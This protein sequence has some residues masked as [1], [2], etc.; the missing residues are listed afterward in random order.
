VS[1]LFV[2]IGMLTTLKPPTVLNLPHLKY[3]DVSGICA[4][5]DVLKAASNL[6]DLRIDFDC[7]KILIDNES[8]CDLLQQRIIRLDV[9]YWTDMESDVFQRLRHL[10]IFQN[11]FK[12]LSESILSTILAQS[13]I[14][15]L[16][17]LIFGSKVPDEI[18]KDLRQWVIDHSHLTVDDSFSVA[19]F[20]NYFILWK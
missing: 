4:I 11:S 20:N 16:T 3:L 2:Y 15:Q 5:F 1:C 19:Y 17:T 9:G 12:I 18:S 13:N 14:K 10:C 8:T 7:L 6:D